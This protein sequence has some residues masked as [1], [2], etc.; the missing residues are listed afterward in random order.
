MQTF[1]V[2]REGL[3]VFLNSTKWGG[4]THKRNKHMKMVG[5]HL[6]NALGKDYHMNFCHFV[7]G[8]S[9][10]FIMENVICWW[11]FLI[12]W[13]RLIHLAGWGPTTKYLGV[14]VL[15]SPYIFVLWKP[16]WAPTIW[17]WHGNPRRYGKILIVFCIEIDKGLCYVL[18]FVEAF[19]GSTEFVL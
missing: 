17:G 5:W 4:K 1:F 13:R 9:V 2:E 16:N 3:L 8:T 10:I 7:S 19:L 18:S 14:V 11:S 6:V 12:K 15:D